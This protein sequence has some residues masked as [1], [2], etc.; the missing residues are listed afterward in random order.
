MFKE[1]DRVRIVSGPWASDC[2]TVKKVTARTLK[3]KLDS[4]H[5]GLALV[6]PKDAK[7]IECK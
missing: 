7:L 6:N 3:V 5:Q 1:G 2:G 4:S